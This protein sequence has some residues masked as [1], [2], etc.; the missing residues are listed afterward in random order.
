[1]TEAH[2]TPAEDRQNLRWVVQFE[3]FRYRNDRQRKA[4]ESLDRGV[5]NR[6][7]TIWL[8]V[9]TPGAAFDPDATSPNLIRFPVRSFARRFVSTFGGRLIGRP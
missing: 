9:I 8:K 6:I 2:A 7:L 1:M 3:D 4:I 5:L